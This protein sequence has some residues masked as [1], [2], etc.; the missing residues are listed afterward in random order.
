LVHACLFFGVFLN[1]VIIGLL[2]TRFS[3]NQAVELWGT[4]GMI[5]AILLAIGSRSRLRRNRAV[6]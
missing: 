6:V 2:R 5:A 4:A 1:P 3:L